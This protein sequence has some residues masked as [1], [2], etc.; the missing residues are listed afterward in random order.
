MIGSESLSKGEVNQPP[1]RVPLELF[2]KNVFF[3]YDNLFTF[4]QGRANAPQNLWEASAAL[5]G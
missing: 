1:F 4:L 2:Y 5:T 3:L